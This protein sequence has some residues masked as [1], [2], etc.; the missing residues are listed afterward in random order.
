[1]NVV[2]RV[3]SSQE[4]GSGHL[5]RDL[6][7][8]KRLIVYKNAKIHFISRDLPG[9]INNVVSQD[10]SLKT[11]PRHVNDK[12][13]SGYAAWLGVSPETDARETKTILSL[14]G[15]VD[16][17]IIDHYGIDFSWER[18]V[19]D[20]VKKILVIDDLANRKHDCDIL[21]DQ[22]FSSGD[23]EQYRYLVPQECRLL[24]GS[25]YLLL[26]DEFYEFKK[27]L[28]S[29]P[30]KQV[31]NILIFFGGSDKTGET[32]KTIKAL[33]DID[34]NNIAV[35]VVVGLGNE[36][37]YDIEQMCRKMNFKFYCQTNNMAELMAKADLGIGAGGVSLWERCFLHLPSIV[38]AVAE[39]QLKGCKYCHD[40][41]ITHYIGKS[42]QVSVKD[43]A[44]AIEYL[45]K[46]NEY[47]F[48]ICDNLKKSFSS[49]APNNIVKYL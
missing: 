28:S 33:S 45:M 11:L 27:E 13:L 44:V 14:I 34:T 20:Y 19:R 4:I 12:G 29:T 40:R 23:G 43:M 24:V 48:A 35:D 46:N 37:R 16:L 2:F 38:V 10:I 30:N 47:R 42:G 36:Q 31:K 7:L 5:M 39:N 49:V 15:K 1:M 6:T 21:L 41:G 9:N 3:D 22:N 8:A 32:L 17:L 25:N 18:S 26:R